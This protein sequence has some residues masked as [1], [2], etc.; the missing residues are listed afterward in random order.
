[1]YSVGTLR[2]LRGK[3]VC[4]CVLCRP[5]ASRGLPAPACRWQGARQ[6]AGASRGFKEFATGIAAASHLTAVGRSMEHL[7]ELGFEPFK[8]ERALQEFLASIRASIRGQAHLSARFERAQRSRWLAL[9]QIE[10][11][12]SF[13]DQQSGS[14][15]S[16]RDSQRATLALQHPSKLGTSGHEGVA[17]SWRRPA[18]A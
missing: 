8:C 17:R 13:W 16:Q 5:A 3:S 4:G 11:R 12:R 15:A 6:P 1:M 9:A 10:V 7:L 2:I 14:V 18:I